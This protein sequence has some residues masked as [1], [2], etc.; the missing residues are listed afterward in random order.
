MIELSAVT[1][2]GEQAVLLNIDNIASITADGTQR[3]QLITRDGR[4]LQIA[5][6]Y[7]TVRAAILRVRSG[8]E[9]LISDTP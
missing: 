8:F 7:A 4:E 9:T 1:P 6:D 2:T 5:S 3:T